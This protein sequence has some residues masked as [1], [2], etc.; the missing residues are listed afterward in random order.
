[1]N[2]E[3]FKKTIKEDISPDDKVVCIQKDH[4]QIVFMDSGE[5]YYKSENDAFCIATERPPEQMLKIKEGLE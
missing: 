2:W 1:M 5:V 3:D 4:Y